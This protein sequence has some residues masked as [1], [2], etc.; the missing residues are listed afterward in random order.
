MNLPLKFTIEVITVTNYILIMN[1]YINICKQFLLQVVAES[2]KP[3]EIIY[4]IMG[5]EPFEMYNAF[6]INPQSKL[7][8]PYHI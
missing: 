6:T 4:S 5:V 7:I 2:G 3:S 8:H 1:R